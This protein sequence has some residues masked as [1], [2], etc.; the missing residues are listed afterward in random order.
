ERGNGQWQI[1]DRFFDCDRP[2]A[3]IPKGAGEIWTLQNS[4]GGWQHPIHIHQEEFLILARNGRAPAPGERG[5][6]DVV[7]LGFNDEVRVFK[8]FRD[9]LERYPMHC[10]NTVHEDHAMMV[11]WDIVPG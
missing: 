9:T 10:H 8:R 2:A 3:L 5:R 6:K 7:R 1:N 11:R 4:S